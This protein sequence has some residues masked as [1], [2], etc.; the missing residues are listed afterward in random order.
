MHQLLKPPGIA[1]D[2]NTQHQSGIS[3]RNEEVTITDTGSV[4]ASDNTINSA[5]TGLITAHQ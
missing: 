3:G 4:T 5:T 1:A 2:I